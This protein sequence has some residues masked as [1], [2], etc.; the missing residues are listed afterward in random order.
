[1]V[2]LA[3]ASPVLLFHISGAL[4]VRLSGIKG[5]R[6]LGKKHGQI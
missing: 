1:M 5:E 6:F 2:G 3:E 4:W